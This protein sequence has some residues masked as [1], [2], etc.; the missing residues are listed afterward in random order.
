MEYVLIYIGVGLIAGFLA[1]LF[2]IGGGLIIVP[3]LILVFT[4][5]HFPETF[6]L[7]MA[8]GSSLASIIFTSLASTLAHHKH[9]AIQW[10]IVRKISLP[11]VIGTLLGTL[12]AA[13]VSSRNL[14][15]VFVIF[16]TYAATQLILNLKPRP[17]RELPK[18]LGLSAVGSSIGLISSLVG[19]GGGTLS[20]PFLVWC[21][22]GLHRAIAT[23]AAIG[24]P[25]SVSGA[26]GYMVT[27]LSVVELPRLS[28]GFIYLPAMLGIVASSALSAPIGAKLAHRL[29]VSTLKKAFALLLYAIGIKMIHGLI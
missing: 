2:G 27:G 13:H 5:Q 10:K 14:T 26:F 3:A 21:N 25:I 23:S 8:L 9:R 6:V 24:I 22:V 20:V 15:I 11:I 12:L 28:V 1:G 18:L 29:P 4:A 7:H 16:L 17:A 19:I